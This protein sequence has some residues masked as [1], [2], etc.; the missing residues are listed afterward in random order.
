MV[1]FSEGDQSKSRNLI[2]VFQIRKGNSPGMASEVIQNAMCASVGVRPCLVAIPE[3]G[4]CKALN[5]K[6]HHLATRAT[7]L[8]G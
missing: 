8:D 5:G 7:L 6:I 2:A 4:I 3:G 1:A